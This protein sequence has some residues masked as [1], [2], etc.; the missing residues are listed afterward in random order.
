M[1]RSKGFTLVELMTVVA[2]VGILLAIAVPSYNSQIRKSRRAD[3][4]ATLGVMSMAQER[5]R[6][7]SPNYSTNAAALGGA[8][9]SY[10]T[11]S[12][13]TPSGNCTVTGTPACTSANCYRLTADTT[14]TQTG[15][16]ARC[17]TIVYTSMC[18]VVTRSSTPSGQ[19]CWSN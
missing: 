17:A 16:D 19:T 8:T 11:F 3:A 1:K 2:I 12:A 14:G 18:G 4:V 15:D 5:V 9:S 13:T 10:Y 7:D 6:A